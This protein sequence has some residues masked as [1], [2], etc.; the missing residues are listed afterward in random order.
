MLKLNFISNFILL[1]EKKGIL[2]SNPSCQSNAD[3]PVLLGPWEHAGAEV[4]MIPSNSP[5]ARFQTVCVRQFCLRWWKETSGFSLHYV[6]T[7]FQNAV[8]FIQ[9]GKSLAT[10]H[11]DPQMNA[12][13]QILH[14][15]KPS[16]CPFFK[17]E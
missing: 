6:V 1:Q 8:S 15:R 17:S 14:P 9:A 4:G 5:G 11:Q 3:R 16:A 12:Q 7:S 10:R 13:T 2:H